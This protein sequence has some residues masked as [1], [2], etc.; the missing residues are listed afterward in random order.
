MEVPN[1]P[2]LGRLAPA[3]L[4]E[5]YEQQTAYILSALGDLCEEFKY[6]ILTDLTTFN[7]FSLSPPIPLNKEALAYLSKSLGRSISLDCR[8]VE[9]AE[10]LYKEGWTP[11]A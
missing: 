6:A 3:I 9:V 10:K 7:D 11:S 2:A 8:I 4:V 1:N 5:R